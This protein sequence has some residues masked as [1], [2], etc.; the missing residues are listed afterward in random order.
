M[1]VAE[2]KKVLENY[3]DDV[4]IAI[5]HDDG[6]EGKG[7]EVKGTHSDEIR[8]GETGL[9]IDTGEELPPL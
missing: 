8:N 7:W 6:D 1:T 5:W 4:E 3:E 9:F 2:M